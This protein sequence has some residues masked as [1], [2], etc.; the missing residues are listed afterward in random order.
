MQARDASPASRGA[1]DCHVH[2][3]GM[4]RDG[5]GCILSP[6][7]RRKISSRF[8]LRLVGAKR[9]DSTA[10]VDRRCVDHLHAALDGAPSLGTAVLLAMDGVYREDGSLDEER[11]AVMIPN[12]YASRVAA[13]HPKLRWGASVNPA[14]ADALAELD[15]CAAGGAALVKWIP[16]AK[17]FDPSDPRHA[18]FHARMAALGMPLLT[19]V[20]TEMAVATVDA[21]FGA[22][23]R[24]RA[25]LDAGVRVIVAHA[26]GCR[27]LGD[28]ADF[29]R[30]RAEVEARPNL[31][32]DDSA[33]C[34]AH[35]RRRLFR[36]A[37]ATGIRDRVLHG[38]DYPL[39][40]QAWAFADRLGFRAARRIGR[41]P[42]AL[43][44]DLALKAAL[45]VPDAFLT[46]A[47]RVLR[48]VTTP[49][50]TPP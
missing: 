14:R 24:L 1:V 40:P 16:A 32:L 7:M 50:T 36:V 3:V 31:F 44:R 42:S 28:A 20:G 34:L 39:P 25:P 43:E 41:I 18:T 26:G 11:T 13:T 27:L 5:N 30:L 21:R 37:E 15:R 48:P 23:E 49:G 45:G 8:V 33:L 4:D 19:H 6:R 38:S 47:T 46:N 2:L 12:A 17:G 9:G 35:R 29:E 10:D 22:F